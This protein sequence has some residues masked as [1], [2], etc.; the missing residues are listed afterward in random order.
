MG[1][2]KSQGTYSLTSVKLVQLLLFLTNLIFIESS[3]FKIW[4]Y[5]LYISIKSAFSPPSLGSICIAVCR[6]VAGIWLWWST[7][8]FPG[9]WSLSLP[10]L[11]PLDSK[12]YYFI[13]LC[14]T[15]MSLQAS[16]LL[17]GSYIFLWLLETQQGYLWGFTTLVL[18]LG[19]WEIVPLLSNHCWD[20]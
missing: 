6:V 17:R 15:S 19:T 13:L 8:L 2:R 18:T 4:Q 1:V 14:W 11:P 7:S 9:T 3:H 10:G 5:L 16:L 12:C 20:K